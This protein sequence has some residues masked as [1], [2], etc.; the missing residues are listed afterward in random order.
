MCC[1]DGCFQKNNNNKFGVVLGLLSWERVCNNFVLF[2]F[3]FFLLL[4]LSLWG[5]GGAWCYHHHIWKLSPSSLLL[6]VVNRYY[7]SN[8]I[9]L[10][11]TYFI[12]MIFLR[13]PTTHPPV[14]TNQPNSYSDSCKVL[15]CFLLPFFF[16][17]L[18]LLCW[19]V[20]ADLV[21]IFCMLPTHPL[22][23]D[24][25]NHWLLDPKHQP[26][27]FNVRYLLLFLPRCVVV[28]LTSIHHH[29]Q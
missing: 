7:C 19:L 15:M 25:D 24:T 22:F 4:L 16:L 2:L 20:S 6:T 11:T 17:L 12:L 28:A 5:C 13:A 10:I 3:C 27:T 21:V 29:Q 8:Y 18:L 1:C 26:T 9:E 23:R 14:P